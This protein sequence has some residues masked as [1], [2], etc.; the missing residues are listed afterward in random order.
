MVKES[1]QRL[2]ITLPKKCVKGLKTLADL[3]CTTVSEIV[4]MMVNRKSNKLYEQIKENCAIR[5]QMTLFELANVKW[6]DD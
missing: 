1:N 3:N 2:M 4:L 5:N 6:I